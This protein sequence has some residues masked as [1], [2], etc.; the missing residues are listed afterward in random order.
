MR[1]LLSKLYALLCIVTI[2]ISQSLSLISLASTSIASGSALDIEKFTTIAS[3]SALGTE[4]FTTIISDSALNTELATG[5]ALMNISMEESEL[6]KIQRVVLP[7]IQDNSYDFT[8]DVDGLLS[9]YNSNYTEGDN[10]Y[11]SSIKT[12][13]RLNID[14]SHSN[15]TTSF[16]V[17]SNLPSTELFEYTILHST[18]SELETILCLANKS[19]LYY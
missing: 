2:L 8:I 4:N 16:V 1:K 19:I 9:Q 11:F 14:S 12:P 13:A 7:T 3:N 6:P 10:V 15:T 18:V 5:P 17:K